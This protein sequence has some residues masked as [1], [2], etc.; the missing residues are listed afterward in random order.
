[1]PSRCGISRTPNE[2]C[3]IKSEGQRVI[4]GCSNTLEDQQTCLLSTECMICQ[5][6][7]LKGCNGLSEIAI[8][9]NGS[10]DEGNGDTGSNEGSNGENTGNGDTETGSED[11]SK[12]ICHQCNGI[13]CLRTSYQVNQE[14]LNN[15]DICVTVFDGRKS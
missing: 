15:L 2:Y 10:G 5:P 9:D 3:F 6:S 4:R 12:R 7:D 8:D 13:N 11:N 1:M 14:C